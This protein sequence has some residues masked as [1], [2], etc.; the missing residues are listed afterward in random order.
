[1]HVAGYIHWAVYQRGRVFTESLVRFESFCRGRK[2]K[3]IGLLAIRRKQ[4]EKA[5]S[6]KY[7]P[8]S[9]VCDPF[10][11][12]KLIPFSHAHLPI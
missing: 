2:E 6:A 9:R 3:I 8:Q 1:M 11:L 10:F 12:Y 7:H 5:A 4:S